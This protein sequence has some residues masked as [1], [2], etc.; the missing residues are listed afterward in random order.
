M[1]TTKP[2]REYLLL[3]MRRH[4][5]DTQVVTRDTVL[6]LGLDEHWCNRA[7]E[8]WF[9]AMAPDEAGE[10]IDLLKETSAE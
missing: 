2:Q 5:L 8:E 1:S 4:R 9:D 7:V 6:D 3:L 10:I